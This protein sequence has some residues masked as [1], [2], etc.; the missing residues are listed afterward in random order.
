MSTFIFVRHGQSD[1]NANG[2]I[3]TADTKLTEVGVEQAKA[4]AMK[5]KGKGITKI[6][7]SPMIRAQQTAETIAAELG[8]DLAHIKI[9][10]ELR[11]RGLGEVEGKPKNHDSAWYLTNDETNVGIESRAD[12]IKRMRSCLDTLSDMAGG[13]SVL[14]VGHAISGYYLAEAA[15]GKTRFEDFGPAQ[16]LLNADFIEID[17]DRHKLSAESTPTV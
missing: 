4:T 2:Y 17:L 3:A 9:V 10:E 11:E 7:C 14:A 8:I 1:G 12:L 5:V 6:V 15:E 16:E 13:D